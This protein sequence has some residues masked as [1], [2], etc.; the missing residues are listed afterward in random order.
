M[1]SSVDLNLQRRPIDRARVAFVL[2]AIHICA[3]F[4]HYTLRTDS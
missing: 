4:A 3:P 1:V 2:E